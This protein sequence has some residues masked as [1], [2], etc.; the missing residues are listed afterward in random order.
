MK[1]KG[2]PSTLKL[3]LIVLI[4]LLDDA[5]ALALVFLALWYF[6]VD[7]PLWAMVLSGLA[8]GTFIFVL[9]RAV[10]PSLRRKKVTG[11]EG[12][13]GETGEVTKALR[14]EGTIM[15]GGEYWQAKSLDGDID[16]GEEVEITGI[17]GLRLEVR[18][19]QP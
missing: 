3:W 4:A 15:V 2:E 9:H 14:P 6:G 17:D 13:L 19:R 8:A 18:R 16:K 12:M 1:A 5:A 11:A 10:V 7:I